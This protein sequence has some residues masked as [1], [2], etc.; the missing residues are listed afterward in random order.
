VNIRAI[1]TDDEQHAVAVVW[2]GEG[3]RG[4][5]SGPTKK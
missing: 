2:D 3:D 4:P 1:Y 5:G